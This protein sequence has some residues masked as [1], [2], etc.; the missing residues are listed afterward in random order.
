MLLSMLLLL[1]LVP[2]FKF[3]LL[4]TID[5]L[6]YWERLEIFLFKDFYFY[7]VEKAVNVVGFFLLL[8]K[9]VLQ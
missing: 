8:R 1:S 4:K 5:I 6:Y 2:D 9:R 3:K 7:L